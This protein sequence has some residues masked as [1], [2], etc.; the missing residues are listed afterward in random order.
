MALDPAL[1]KKWLEWGGYSALGI[2][3]F[4]YFLFQG[5]P[6]EGLVQSRLGELER[7]AGVKVEIGSVKAGWLF[8]VVASDVKVRQLPVTTPPGDPLAQ[9]DRVVVSLAPFRL[10]VGQ[11]GLHLDA[12]HYGGR[13]NG[14]ISLGRSATVLDLAASNVE[15]AKYGLLASR[16]QVNAAGQVTGTCDLTLAADDLSKSAGKIDLT[17]KNGALRE[18]NPYG[19]VK[20]PNTEFSKGGG[21][22][23]TVK[24]GKASLDDVGLHGDDLDLSLDGEIEL[25]KNLAFSQWNARSAIRASDSF[26][27][28]VSMLDV[29]LGPGKGTDGIYHYKITGPLTRP[30]TPADPGARR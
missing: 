18:S 21:V 17:I 25:R 7:Q 11:L 3:A 30:S 20:I 14:L 6:F 22:T 15:L 2:F 29:F 27:S 23:V 12:K 24:D 26:K 28:Q 13:V 10:F 9:I 8:D 5:F 1:R 16:F 19:I 4:L